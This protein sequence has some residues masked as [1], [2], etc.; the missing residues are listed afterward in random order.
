MT[1]NI[2]RDRDDLKNNHVRTSS[3]LG[4]DEESNAQ[5]K[6]V[7][8]A[9]AFVTILWLGVLVYLGRELWARAFN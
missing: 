1:M 5:I 2:Q 9:G 3:P 8:A 7:F 6:I 4:A